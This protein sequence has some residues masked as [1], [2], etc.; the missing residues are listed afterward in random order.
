MQF[1][2]VFILFV[3][4][5]IFVMFIQNQFS[6][7]ERVQSSVD[8]RL[9]LV[10]KLPNSQAAADYLAEINQLLQKLVNH[11]IAKYPENSEVQQLYKNYNPDSISEGS[12]DSGYTS[13]SVN[14]GEKLILCIRQ[15][16]NTFVEQNVILYVAIHE[17]GHIM[18]KEV[19]HTDKFW[20][21]FKILLEEAVTLGIYKKIDYKEQPQDYCG[22]KI[23]NSII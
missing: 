6:E 14:K 13:Y 2:E 4:I 20:E 17:L 12:P 19:G 1:I 9:Y 16:D 21:N 5:I 15:I 8:K 22:I 3:M 10:R 23:T 18:T 7:V 11:M